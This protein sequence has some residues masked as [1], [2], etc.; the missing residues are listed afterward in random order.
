MQNALGMT[1]HRVYRW[2]LLIEEFGPAIEYIKGIDNTIADAI[3]R[4]E[5]DPDKKNSRL[6]LHQC[7]CHVATSCSHYMQC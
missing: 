6:G 2:R 3:S 5:Y 1:S 7:Y 4:L